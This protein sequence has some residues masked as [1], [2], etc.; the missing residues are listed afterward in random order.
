MPLNRCEIAGLALLTLLTAAPLAALAARPFAVWPIWGIGTLM[1]AALGVFAWRS[2]R[3]PPDVA[4]ALKL[5]AWTVLAALAVL[6]LTAAVVI[7]RQPGLGVIEAGLRGGPALALALA[8]CPGLTWIAVAGALR[9]HL[10]RQPPAA[11][12]GR[13]GAAS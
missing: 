2:E 7:W 10:G 11:G 3:W 13:H 6:A 9:N 12:P 1:L 5:A 8:L 4:G